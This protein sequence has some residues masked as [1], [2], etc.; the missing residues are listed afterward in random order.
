[1]NAARCDPVAR[2]A[3]AH[4]LAINS[5]FPAAVNNWPYLNAVVGVLM[6]GYTPIDPVSRIITFYLRYPGL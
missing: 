3:R 5:V 6:C 2:A 1:M 4:A